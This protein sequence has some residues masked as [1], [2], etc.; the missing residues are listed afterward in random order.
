MNRINFDPIIDVSVIG[1]QT[2]KSRSIS[3]EASN[4]LRKIMAEWA[5]LALYLQLR[6]FS[7]VTGRLPLTKS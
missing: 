1:Y 6:A 5:G 4:I 2:Q 7:G 3:A